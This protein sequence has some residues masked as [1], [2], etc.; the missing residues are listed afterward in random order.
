MREFWPNL[1]EVQKKDFYLPAKI[2]EFALLFAYAIKPFFHDAVQILLL[3]I[4]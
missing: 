1:L 4:P 3:E 2:I